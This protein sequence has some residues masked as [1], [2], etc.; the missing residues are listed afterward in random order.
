ML[1]FSS[2]VWIEENEP[3]HNGEETIMFWHEVPSFVDTTVTY[4]MSQCSVK[5]SGFIATK[6][7]GTHPLKY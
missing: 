2:S 3:L 4:A 6:L 5:M 1:Q 7:A